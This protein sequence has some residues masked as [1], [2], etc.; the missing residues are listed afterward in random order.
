M[1]SP[2]G[3]VLA[4]AETFGFA[5]VLYYLLGLLTI[6]RGLEAVAARSGVNVRPLLLPYQ[7]AGVDV[8]KIED[9]LLAEA[10]L[11]GSMPE[12]SSRFGLRDPS[13]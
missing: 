12:S 9:M 1:P 7:Q 6:D 13:C 10:V 2:P 4:I 8:D 11:S 3:R 5:T